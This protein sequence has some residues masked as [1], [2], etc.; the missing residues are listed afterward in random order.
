MATQVRHPIWLPAVRSPG[1]STFAVLYALDSFARASVAS[2]IPIQ[3]YHL[4]QSEQAVSLLYTV[5]SLAG[6]SITLTL[7]LLILRLAR[8]WVYTIGIGLLVLGSAFFV[9]DTLAGQIVGMF[10]RVAGASTLSITLNLYIMDYIRKTDFMQAESMR[11]AWS[12]L[13]WTGGPT[14][15]VVL[16]TEFGI[17]AAH[18]VV[19]VSSV[20][21]LALFWYFRLGDN[22]LIRPGK[23]RPANPLRNVGRFVSQ[24]RLRVAWLIA[25]G[26]SCFWTSFFVYAPI[27]MVVT[28]E[29]SL[30][31]GLLVSA[32]NAL[33]F[34]AL[35]WG[36]AGKRFGARRTMAF[37][38]AAMAAALFA[39]AAT[40]EA[41][42]LATGAFLLVTAFFA[43]ALDAL[44][45]TVFMR[46]V[47]PYERPQMTAVYRT[48]LDLSEITPPLVFSVTLAF[49]GLGSVF[50]TLAIFSLVCGW[51]T[52]RYLPRRI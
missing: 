49:F 3:A 48:Y 38:F 46:A 5:V 24:P 4:L 34:T 40:G 2:V 18:A 41:F 21:L 44:G 30:A 17:V 28:G 32:A 12:T 20:M 27:L 33:L 7:P 43:I 42:P 13:A 29:G 14:L 52:W 26:R 1:A 10:A 36:R 23:T 6:L 16:Y 19:V 50:A 37:A 9:T 45:S 31:G 47:H 15:G 22:P 25:F 35:I 39:A 8:R 51:I 11:L